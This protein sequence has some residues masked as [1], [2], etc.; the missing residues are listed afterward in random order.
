MYSYHLTGIAKG[1]ALDQRNSQRVNIHGVK[2]RLHF[3]S[4]TST[5]APMVMNVAILV[6]KNGSS[7][8]TGT[9]NEFFRAYG[10]N[11][12]SEFSDGGGVTSVC[13]FLDYAYGTINPEKHQ[14]LN[15]WR[16]VLGPNRQTDTGT[17]Y[18]DGFAA[19]YKTFIKY[20]PI[21]R[22]IQFDADGDDVP[23]EDSIFLCFWAD[24]MGATRTGAASG[25]YSRQ[26]FTVTYFKDAD[27]A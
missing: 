25:L 3:Q 11:Q 5:A 7:I 20:V 8:F 12:T 22:Q 2:I 18:K 17:S 15:R 16:F 21:K 14:V 10:T 9:N 23:E 6:P 19:P 27:T 1:T 4:V 24:V 13:T 26:M